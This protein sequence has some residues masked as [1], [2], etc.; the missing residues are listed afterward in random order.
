MA[1]VPS[2]GCLLAKNQ[3]YR[4]FSKGAACTWWFKSFFHSKS[5]VLNV[6][7]KDLSSGG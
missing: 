2:I 5:V 3:Y 4:R 1:S 7:S 6:R